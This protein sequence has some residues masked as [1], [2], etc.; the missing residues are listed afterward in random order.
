MLIINSLLQQSPSGSALI[1]GQCVVCPG[2]TG[3]ASGASG[4]ICFPCNPGTYGV[5]G[6]CI[7][8][9]VGSYSNTKSAMSCTP[10][11]SAGLLGMSACTT[12]SDIYAT[13]C[14]ASGNSLTW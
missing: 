4:T 5:A 14:D 12:C 11:A 7:A 10:C 6:V 13:T 8:C 3:I 1:T 9:P 2:G